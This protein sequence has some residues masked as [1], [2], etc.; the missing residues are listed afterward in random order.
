MLRVGIHHSRASQLPLQHG[1][2]WQTEPALCS[3]GSPPKHKAQHLRRMNPLDTGRVCP[4]WILLEEAGGAT[5]CATGRNNP[6]RC[7][8]SV[9][10]L[11]HVPTSNMKRVPSEEGNGGAADDK[12]PSCGI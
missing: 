7:P 11:Q 3:S 9:P 6:A 4:R 1:G 8:F 12:N 5:H 2:G 10:L